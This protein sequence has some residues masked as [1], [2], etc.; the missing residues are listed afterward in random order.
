MVINSSFSKNFAKLNGGGIGVNSSSVTV[1]NSSFEFNRAITNGGAIRS[2]YG[3][4]LAL[5]SNFTNNTA[6]HSGGIGSYNNITSINSIFTN[7]TS[8][9]NGTAISSTNLTVIN[10]TFIANHAVNETI[11]DGYG[12]AIVINKYK[13]VP[14]NATI[15][16]SKF[17][18]NTASANGG[19]I[20]NKESYFNV[21]NCT[22]IGNDANMTGGAIFNG[23]EMKL[24]NCVFI[25]NNATNGGAIYSRAGNMTIINS[26]FSDN[27][28]LH[29]GSAIYSEKDNMNITNS[30]FK[31]HTAEFG[32][33]IYDND[34]DMNITGSTFIGNNATDGGAIYSANGYMEIV[35]SKFINNTATSNGSAIYSADGDM[36]IT[37]SEFTNNS[38]INGGAIFSAKGDMNITSSNFN[39]NTATNGGAI[40]SDS[41]DINIFDST[42]TGNKAS[43]DGG[44]IFNS[45]DMNITGTTFNNNEA[46]NGGAIYGIDGNVTVTNSKFVNNNATKGGAIH[47]TNVT[48]ASEMYLKVMNSE[49]DSNK[50][51]FGDDIYTSYNTTVSGNNY[52]KNSYANIYA[53]DT[54]VNCSIVSVLRN[55]TIYLTPG[56]KYEVYAAVF[57]DGASINGYN[58]TITDGKNNYT[59]VYK[60]YGIYEVD[61][62]FA[63]NSTFTKETYSATLNNKTEGTNFLIENG[64]VI[65]NRNTT[66]EVE[67]DEVVEGKNITGNVTIRDANGDIANVTGNVTV[68]VD[69]QNFTVEVNEGVGELDLPNNLNPGNNTLNATFEG[70]EDYGS[71]NTTKDFNM[72]KQSQL[73][74]EVSDIEYGENVTGNI[75]LKDINGNIANITGEVTIELEGKNYTI[76]V[77]EGKGQFNIKDDLKSGN[78]TIKAYFAGNDLYTESNT[79]G[80]FRVKDTGI[81]IIVDDFTKYYGNNGTL[82]ITITDLEGNLLANKTVTITINGVTYTYTTDANGN[83]F[84]KIDLIPGIYETTISCGNFTKKVNVTVISTIVSSDL[85]KYYLKRYTF[86]RYIL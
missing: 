29:N 81:I 1:I 36:N 7:N 50:E 65:V 82:N 27:T 22:F 26:T 35:D 83:I 32:G 24:T 10:S 3:N 34:G 12:G 45:G 21:T 17:I 9:G 48:E 66:I 75:T 16:N 14:G 31:N 20:C 6:Y 47:Y 55:A 72:K 15:I 43:A 85:I 23:G 25:G 60:G 78:Y 39:Q 19:A 59:A 74:I 52:T 18:N 67:L 11:T 86:L 70:N 62:T 56:S 33:A 61:M 49:F 80:S 57:A 64:T 73:E 71:S 68:E 30:T 42:F 77:T 84:M 41:D 8:Y 58:I 76:N 28:V 51:E 2:D 44:A 5:N 4:I 40:F 38:A 79:T 37:G 63:I 54:I 69:G 46:I 13:G 53:N